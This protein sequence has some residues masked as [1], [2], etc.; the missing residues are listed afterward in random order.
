MFRPGKSGRSQPTDQS[1]Q[2]LLLP[3]DRDG[4]SSPQFRNLRIEAAPHVVVDVPIFF[5]EMNLIIALYL[6][7]Q[8]IRM[9]FK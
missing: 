5:K 2:P 6:T 3:L 4:W 8:L 1:K 9:I 7:L